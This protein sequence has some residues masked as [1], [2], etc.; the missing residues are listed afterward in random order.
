MSGTKS[1][2]GFPKSSL[3]RNVFG[4]S[5]EY[6]KVAPTPDTNSTGSKSDLEQG[7]VTYVVL[8]ML[9]VMPMTPSQNSILKWK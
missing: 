3:V 1:F 6:E 9:L 8:W 4:F 5:S 2:C 7:F